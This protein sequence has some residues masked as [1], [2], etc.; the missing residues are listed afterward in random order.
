M[1][2]VILT[3]IGRPKPLDLVLFRRFGREVPG[4]VESTYAQ[5]PGLADLGPLLPRGTKVVVATPAPAPAKTTRKTIRL[6]D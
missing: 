2:T 5:N 3:V 1:A 4:L 6:Y